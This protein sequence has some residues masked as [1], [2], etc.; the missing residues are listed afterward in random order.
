MLASPIQKLPAMETGMNNQAYRFTRSQQTV[1]NLTHS[2]CWFCE[3]SVPIGHRF[4]GRDCAEAFEDDELAAEKR[5]LAKQPETT[6]A[7]V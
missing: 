4:C 3:H 2:T 1:S 5:M 7:F 6:T